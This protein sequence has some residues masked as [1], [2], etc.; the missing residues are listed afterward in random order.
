VV[1]PT[2]TLK[3]IVLPLVALLALAAGVSA[4]G[5]PST[6]ASRID[7]AVQQVRMTTLAP[8]VSVAIVQDGRIVYTHTYGTAQLDRGKAATAEMRYS[9]GSISK[10]FTATAVLMLAEEGKLS[11]DDPVSKYVSG[12]TRGDEIT[13]RQILSMTSGYQDYWPQDYVMPD[14][15]KPTTPQQIVAGWA[16][17]PLDFEPGT[18]WQYSNTNYVIAGMI[19][20]KAGGK[21]LVDFLGE[22][23]FRPLK[24]LSV[25]NV[26]EAPLGGEDPARYLRYATGPARPAPKEGKG[27][28]S[29]AGELAMTARDLAL[30]DISIIDQTVL[31]PASYRT[32]QTDTLLKSGVATGYGLG[33]NVGMNGGRRMISHG[34]EVSGFTASNQVFPDDRAAIVV[35]VNMDATGAPGQI[36]SRIA[37][38]IFTSTV[39]DTEQA[40]EQAKKI[41]AG[42]QRGQIDR[43]L[44]SS[45]AS[46]YFTPQALADFQTSLAPLGTPES[47]VA[48]PNFL[49]GGMTGRTF[50]IRAGGKDLRLTT[51][52]LPDGKLE[53]YQIAGR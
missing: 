25:T 35:L 2:V 6:V 16:S 13:V 49:R 22:R 5:L 20:E 37:T 40:T 51:F 36:A 4:Q 7:E 33:V 34:G 43:S 21:P 42:L 12:T 50:R 27:W 30:W 44:L 48:D 26:D 1:T 9:I 24:M 17:K 32:M 18:K 38:A 23:V 47:F 15:L 52:T 31:K 45:N 3:R 41:F 46:A 11:L 28:L 53:Q 8:S 19:V 39:R 10:Q 14:M 29:A